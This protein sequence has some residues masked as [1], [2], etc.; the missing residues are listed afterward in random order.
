MD[1]SGTLEGKPDSA[2]VVWWAFSKEGDLGRLSRW[3][4]DLSIIL[5]DNHNGA[6]IA[7]RPGLD[8][9]DVKIGCRLCRRAPWWCNF[10]DGGLERGT[11]FA[12]LRGG[13]N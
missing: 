10:G 5:E 9:G 12:D 7:S 13:K 4:M 11:E 6:I 1:L 3:T 2:I 8:G